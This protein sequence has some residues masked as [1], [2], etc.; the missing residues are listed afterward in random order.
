MSLSGLSMAMVMSLS[1]TQ[2]IN[3]RAAYGV[4]LCG[5]ILLIY[6]IEKME[7]RARVKSAS[8]GWKGAAA[9][10]ACTAVAVCGVLMFTGLSNR[11]VH[12]PVR[13]ELIRYMEQNQDKLFL[14][15]AASG[16]IYSENM[17]HP[18]DSFDSYHCENLVSLGGWLSASK[19]EEDLLKPYG[20]TNLYKDMVDNP[21]VYVLLQ[22]GK[23]QSQEAYLN[24][25]YNRSEKT[26]IVYRLINTIGGTAVYQIVTVP[27]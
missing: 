16:G 3:Y 19:F 26:K 21:R 5:I 17:E 11:Q 18:L 13:Q 27:K 4:F 25:H 24:R 10:T 9:V 22:P 7:L 6:S 12:Y 1:Y 23:V 14:R 8:K 15:N 20:I 2:R